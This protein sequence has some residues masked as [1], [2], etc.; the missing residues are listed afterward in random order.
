MIHVRLMG[1]PNDVA[2]LAACLRSFVEVLEASS[3]HQNRGAS[4]LVRR[5][6]TVLVTDRT[7]KSIVWLV[8]AQEGGD[9]EEA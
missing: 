3:D 6:L 4:T 7:L 9:G 8:Q 1:T 5:S 2:T